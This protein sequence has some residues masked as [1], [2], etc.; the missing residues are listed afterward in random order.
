MDQLFADAQKC[1]RCF[2]EA[3]IHVPLPDPKNGKSNALIMF[4]NERPGRVGTGKS[5]YISFENDDPSANHFR[6]C[7]EQLKISR[8]KIFITNACL[9]YPEINDYNDTTPKIREIR[10]CH[11]WL[12]KQIRIASPKL[13]VT[14][15]GTALRSM[16]LLFPNSQQLKAY[17]L[18]D[19]IGSV[20]NDTTPW[21]YPLYHTSMRARLHRN[22]ELQKQD[23]LKINT[24]LY[25]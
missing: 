18:K 19:N 22:A 17:R 7:F 11:H 21:I 25:G 1:N 3:E 20:I 24:I 12:R 5:G 8:E 10:H 16:K 15:G 2:G 13:I 4:I 6:Y 14:V 23:W 9:C